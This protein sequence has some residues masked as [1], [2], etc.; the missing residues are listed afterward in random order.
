MKRK[1]MVRTASLSSKAVGVLNEAEIDAN[2]SWNVY[3]EALD[4]AAKAL[5]MPHSRDYQILL[6]R[7]GDGFR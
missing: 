5:P 6:N 7:I 4:S 2:R 3:S 1:P